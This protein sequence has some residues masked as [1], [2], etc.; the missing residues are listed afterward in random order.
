MNPAPR[1]YWLQ[2]FVGSKLCS[3]SC[4]WEG[5]VRRGGMVKV[6]SSK[7]QSHQWPTLSSLSFKAKG[8]KKSP[9]ASIRGRWSS[10]SG[11]AMIR[12][13]VTTSLSPFH[14]RT[15]GGDRWMR[16]TLRINGVHGGTRN[17][18]MQQLRLQSLLPFGQ[19]PIFAEIPHNGD[20][21][22]YNMWL[23][24]GCP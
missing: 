15:G 14:W 11:A 7:E 18:S 22:L 9:N 24:R 2:F 16:R 19:E 23:R 13:L 6:W 1:F 10:D 21:S 8:R 17:S 4:H 20:T 5:G 12:R 3:H